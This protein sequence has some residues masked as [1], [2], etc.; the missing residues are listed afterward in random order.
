MQGAPVW[1]TRLVRSLQ[2]LRF[3]TFTSLSQPA[4]TMSGIF[5]E[6]EKTTQLTQSVCMSSGTASEITHKGIKAREGV[7]AASAAHASGRHSS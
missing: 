4:E 6:G 1:P 5:A 2:L 7:W 3:Q